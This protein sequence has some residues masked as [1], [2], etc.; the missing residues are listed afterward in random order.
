MNMAAKG[1]HSPMLLL[2]PPVLF[3]IGACVVV[4]ALIAITGHPALRSALIGTGLV[5]VGMVAL[6]FIAAGA[7][8]HGDHGTGQEH[9]GG[10]H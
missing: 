3:M 1:H 10:H 7:G 4:L 8:H 6:N 2:Q 9:G 5:V